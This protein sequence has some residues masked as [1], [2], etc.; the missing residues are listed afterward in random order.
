LAAASLLLLIII[1]IVVV[2]AA[3]LG[4]CPG[5]GLALPFRRLGD[6]GVLGVALCSLG[7]LVC[8]AEERRDILDVM[9]GE[10]LQH[11]LI[12]YSLAKCNYHRSIRDMKNGI[13][14]LGEPLDEGL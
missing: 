3:A 12:P 9:G 4:M 14:N 11:L 10:L 8:Q 6:W 2:V 13:A 7:A 1:I 5:V